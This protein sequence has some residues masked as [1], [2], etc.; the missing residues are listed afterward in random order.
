MP[1]TLKCH[2]VVR[3]SKEVGRRR[4][5]T[6]ELGGGGSRGRREKSSH[7][8]LVSE[9]ISVRWTYLYLLR[10]NRCSRVPSVP[11][12]V[13]YSEGQPEA[14]EATVHFKLTADVP[15]SHTAPCGSCGLSPLKGGK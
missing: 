10:K 3:E 2:G 12:C 6:E 8:R 4:R 7:T 15:D 13:R 14:Q 1:G 9:L 11:V 5:R